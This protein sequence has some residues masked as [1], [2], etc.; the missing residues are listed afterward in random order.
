LVELDKSRSSGK[1]Q[2]LG[3]NLFSK[4]TGGTVPSELQP[5]VPLQTAVS[6]LT[7]IASAA[8]TAIADYD[9]L[10][11][12]NAAAPSPPVFAARLS[13]LLRTL[14]NAEAVVNDSIQKRR[15]LISGIEKLLESNRKA[16][17]E[18]EANHEKLANQKAAAESKKREVEDT[19]MRGL[20]SE[21]SD[22][23]GQESSG[24]ESGPNGYD[25]SAEP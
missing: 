9:K 25:G 15:D 14:N 17:Q 11:D 24:A 16:L 20:G 19:I 18:D 22:A 6:K 13:A 23:N 21:T 10:M 5:L 4:D 1:K 8:S 3:G 12:S 2:L 7:S